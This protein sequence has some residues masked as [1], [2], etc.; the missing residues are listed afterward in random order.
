MARRPL[1]AGDRLASAF[2][3]L[4]FVMFAVLVV[5]GAAFNWTF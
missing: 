3:V 5:L 4:P 1:P 2:L